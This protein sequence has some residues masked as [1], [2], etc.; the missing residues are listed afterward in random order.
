MGQEEFEYIWTGILWNVEWNQVGEKTR[1]SKAAEVE[2][3]LSTEPY[4]KWACIY[5][6]LSFSRETSWPRNQTQIFCIVGRLFTNWAM[7]SV[8]EFLNGPRF[9]LSSDDLLLV[10]RKH[11]TPCLVRCRVIFKC[12][13]T[14][15]FPWSQCSGQQPHFFLIF[16]RRGSDNGQTPGAYIYSPG[17]CPSAIMLWRRYFLSFIT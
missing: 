2:W 15:T 7:Y 3:R 6:Q 9:T 12:R 5:S 13:L 17:G 10:H 11:T 16:L 8:V 14:F 1:T 4:Q